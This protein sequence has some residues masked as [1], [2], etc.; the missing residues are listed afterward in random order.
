MVLRAISSVAVLFAGLLAHSGP[1]PKPVTTQ[2]LANTLTGLVQK[3]DIATM[4]G[5]VN[6]LK[7]LFVPGNATAQNVLGS[8]KQRLKYLQN[9]QTAR[10]I[11]LDHVHV[12]LRTGTVKYLGDNT[13]RIYAVVS[14]RFRYHHLKGNQQPSWFGLGVYHWYVISRHQGHWFI[15][16]DIFIDPL[17]QDTRLGGG[18]HPATIHVQFQGSDKIL[19]KGSKSA[20]SYAKTYCGAAPGCQNHERY[21][22]RYYD[23]NWQG[24]D[25][26]NFISQVLHA[27]GFPMTSTWAWNFPMGD[28]TKA[29]VNAHSLAHYLVASGRATLYAH[30]TLKQLLTPLAPGQPTPLSAIRPGDLIGYYERGRMVHFGLV[31]GFDPDGY[32]VI[33]SHSAD[34]YREPFDLGWDR[35]TR[36]FLY[37]PH[38]PH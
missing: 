10:G 30:G 28:G 19:A 29:W 15:K 4:T 35:S 32:P 16:N 5:N 33:I 1:A 38:Y 21:N 20:I 13:Y 7:Q 9:W 8:A 27:G 18:A 26:T 11:H 31:V 14:E 36:Y 22:P 2:A 37:H 3:E 17:N 34:R 6:Q 12:H 23:F 25:C 24:G